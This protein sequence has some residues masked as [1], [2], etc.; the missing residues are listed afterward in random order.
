MVCL[1]DTILDPLDP[2]RNIILV[3]RVK[4]RPHNALPPEGDP[5]PPV[6][7]PT[8]EWLPA[9]RFHNLSNSLRSFR[10]ALLKLVR[11]LKTS[12]KSPRLPPA[13]PAMVIKVLS[14]SYEFLKIESVTQKVPNF[15]NVLSIV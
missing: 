1:G 13:R 4:T 6:Y 10:H 14:F 12:P 15:S 7:W 2:L 5:P 3:V 9:L 8:G 11:Y